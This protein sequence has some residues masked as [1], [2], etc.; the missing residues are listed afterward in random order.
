MQHLFHVAGAS[1]YI[2][3]VIHT[4]EVPGLV[5]D[6]SQSCGMRL[7]TFALGVIG[8]T[9][10]RTS[11]QVVISWLRLVA[12]TIETIRWFVVAVFYI[13]ITLV[14]VYAQASGYVAIKFACF[15]SANFSSFYTEFGVGTCWQQS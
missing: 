10:A 4:V 1:R 7:L 11:T 12:E 14:V 5:W 15:D 13:Y 8:A 9:G 2:N 6:R 3:C